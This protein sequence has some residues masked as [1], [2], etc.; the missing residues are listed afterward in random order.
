MIAY[1]LRQ[2]FSGTVEQTIDGKPVEVPY[3]T[4]GVI[5]AG[6]RDIDVRADLDD[7]AGGAGRIIVADDDIA[8]IIALD[9]YPPL[10]RVDLADGD[11][12]LEGA[13]YGRFTVDVLR[14]DP[15]LADAKGASKAVKPELVAALEELDRRRDEGDTAAPL[16]ELTVAELV[17]AAHDRGTT[18]RQEA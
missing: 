1:E 14:K 8:A 16:E 17:K 12:T 15:R 9:A 3:F 5:T 6:E 7:E 13:G 2:A 11:V 10:K 18:D 4:G